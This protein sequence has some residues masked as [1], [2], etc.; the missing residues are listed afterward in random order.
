[1]NKYIL[2]S[3]FVFGCQEVV[4]P[5]VVL[6]ISAYNNCG[7]Y[8]DIPLVIDPDF[9]DSEI[10][11][12][13]LGA[14]YWEDLVGIDFGGLPVSDEDCSR[15]NKVPGCIVRSNKMEQSD[16]YEIP[17]IM[18]YMETIRKLD[19]LLNEVVSHEIGHYIGLPHSDDKQSIMY[20]R[21]VKGDVDNPDYDAILYE[22]FCVYGSL[23]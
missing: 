14:K 18:L 19:Y 22:E 9:N 3:L 11:Q 21:E 17:S 6:G 4:N 8:K 15:G 2:L 20:Y 23:K 13:R 5:D 7:E 12:I 16:F 10:Y 1:M